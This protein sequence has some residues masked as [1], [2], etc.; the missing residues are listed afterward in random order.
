MY[1][2]LPLG[3]WVSVVGEGKCRQGN[4]LADLPSIS[5]VSAVDPQALTVKALKNKTMTNA[6]NFS[7][8]AFRVPANEG[9]L[10]RNCS[11]E[12]CPRV[13]DLSQIDPKFP[14]YL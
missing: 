8:E 3:P 14:L 6:C 5:G 7:L 12:A 9:P 11:G 13:P 2:D 1:T 4:V 10:S